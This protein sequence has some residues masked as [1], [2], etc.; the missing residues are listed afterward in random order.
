M[1][2][3]IVLSKMSAETIEN[4]ISTVCYCMCVYL[5]VVGGWG[6]LGM[7]ARG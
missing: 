5:M 4:L 6:G 7:G 1:F 2:Y 3:A